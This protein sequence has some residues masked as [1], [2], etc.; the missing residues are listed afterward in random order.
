MKPKPWWNHRDPPRE[1]VAENL[2][3]NQKPIAMAFFG[4]GDQLLPE[5]FC[6]DLSKIEETRKYGEYASMCQQNAGLYTQN[7]LQLK[8]AKTFFIM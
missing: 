8:K 4:G 2:P 7:I 3:G 1:V 5:T 6:F